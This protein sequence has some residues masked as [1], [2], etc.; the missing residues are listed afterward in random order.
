MDAITA[1]VT[2]ADHP[3]GLG[4]ARALR[5]AG[6]EVVGFTRRPDA[7]TCHSRAWREIR[8]VSGAGT[9]DEAEELLGAAGA[10]GG[11]VF[12]LPTQDGLVAELSRIRD[13]LPANVRM[14]LPPS[15]VVETLLE[16]TRFAEWARGEGFP[17]PRSSVVKS[18]EELKASLA[19][20][21]MPVIV[22]PLVRTP[23]WHDA[24]PVDKVIRM[25]SARDL[26][27]VPFDLF[28]VAPAYVLSEWI[29]G[30][31]SDVFFCLTYLDSDSEMVASF[32]G[33]KLLQYPRLTGSTAICTD[34]PDADLE[35][36]TADL[37]RRAGCQGLASL[38]VK[39]S[40]VD[41]RCY[42]TEPTVGR[43]NLQSH[44]A[45][46]AGVNLHGVA[47]RHAWGEGYSDLIGPQRRCIWFE[48]RGLFEILT[49]RTGIPVP[50]RLIA[51]EALKA[52]WPSGAHF[53][54]TDPVPFASM[55]WSWV[56]N[57]MRR[58]RG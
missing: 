41:G 2:G 37:F 32:T 8:R 6:H 51:G 38:E 34:R 57:G 35:A 24:S 56:R 26:E 7:A 12:L 33:R 18:E 54:V 19:E 27:N 9:R 58:L 49:T 40:A 22:K 1:F 11:P 28:A 17:L 13:E 36:L 20:L 23:E 47:L 39:Q 10:F 14:T 29:E 21:T 48:E 44:A 50:L 53:S 25:D 15:E 45:V 43:P 46:K 31:D 5:A 4:T 3:T 16:K 52:R 30:E 42:I 55:S